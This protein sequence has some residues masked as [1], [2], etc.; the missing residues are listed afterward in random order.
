MTEN[1]I[2]IIA[3]IGSDRKVRFGLLRQI[4]LHFPAIVHLIVPAIPN[5]KI[6]HIL[7]STRENI[8]GHLIILGYISGTMIGYRT[9]Q[10]DPTFVR[11]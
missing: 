1:I 6:A 7:N 2:A 9:V 5:D 3:S 8:F 11:E 4:R 10:N